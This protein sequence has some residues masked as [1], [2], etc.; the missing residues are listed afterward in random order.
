MDTL[1]LNRG[2]ADQVVTSTS[3][4]T[5]IAIPAD[6]F[7]HTNPNAVV[8]LTARQANGEALPPWMTFDA[9]TGKFTVRAAPGERRVIEVRVQAS[10]G[11]GRPVST[12]FKIQVGA[13][14]KRGA[15]LEPAGR[16]GL[17]AQLRMAAQRQHLPLERMDQ[18]ARLAK[19]PAA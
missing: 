9:A 13:A 16:P 2:M 7:A 19:R 17:T 12:T 14:A 5:Q 6:A 18:L 8:T 1:V 4:V 15:M 10:D 3:G 11:S